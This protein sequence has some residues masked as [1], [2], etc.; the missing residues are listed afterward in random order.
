MPKIIS[1]ADLRNA[2]AL[3]ALCHAER[4]PVFIAQGGQVD[5]VIMS[6]EAYGDLTGTVNQDAAIRKA[7]NEY[8][9]DGVLLDAHDALSTLR[10][11][12]FG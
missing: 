8:A 4:E 9:S 11:K 7:E 12:H 5:M 2:D 10:K 6:M 3:S 1:V